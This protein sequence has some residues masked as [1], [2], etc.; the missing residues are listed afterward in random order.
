MYDGIDALLKEIA[1]FGLDALLKNLGNGLEKQLLELWDTPS[2]PRETRAKRTPE[3]PKER[4][5]LP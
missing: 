2:K 4:K 5:I 3:T 1:D